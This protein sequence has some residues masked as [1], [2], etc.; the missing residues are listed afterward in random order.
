MS[1][2][3]EGV[4]PF[5]AAPTGGGVLTVLRDRNFLPYFLGNLLSSCGTWFHNIA[6]TLLVYRLTGSVFL[7]GVVNL[8]QFAG[9][10]VLGPSAG[11]AA[12]RF[13][14]RRLLLSAQVAGSCVTATLALLAMTGRATVPIVIAAALVLGVAQTFSV[15]AMLSLVP[16]LVPPSNLAPAVALNIV[17]F[18]VA[19][20]VG[21]VLGALVVG[22]FGVATAFSVNAVSFMALAGALLVVRPRGQPVRD[23]SIRPRLR[24]TIRSVRERPA[25]WRVFVAATCASFAIDP[26]TTLTPEFATRIFGSSDTLVGWFVGA[27]GTGAVLAGLWVSQRPLPTD[28]LLAGRMGLLVASLACFAVT[29]NLAVGL[30]ALVVAGFAFIGLSAAALTRVQH[31]SEDSELGRL[32]ALWSMAFLGSRPIASLFD[33]AL[34]SAVGVRAAMLVM[35]VP[36]VIGGALLVPRRGAGQRRGARLRWCRRPV[37]E[38][39]SRSPAHSAPRRIYLSR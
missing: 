25:I 11:V 37:S 21:P 8:A 29:G 19:R 1:V 4:D 13:D 22:A 20:A 6:Q 23:A 15:P 39:A 30:M 32:M 9:V 3:A 2:E 27:F 14:R 26:V 38:R 34:A 24:D 12:D 10:L 31:S 33:G 18:N 16:Q 28:R 7:V 17:T 35:L 5:A 36:A